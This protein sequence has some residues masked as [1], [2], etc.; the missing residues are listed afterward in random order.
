MN[1]EGA[2]E[3]G[4]FLW[5]RSIFYTKAYFGS[6][7]FHLRWF[8]I[9]H[10][11]IVS[12]PDRQEPD[13]HAIVYPLFH[14]IHVDNRRL[15][16][17]IIHPTEGR[18]DF[19]LMAPS[20]AIFDAVVQGLEEYMNETRPLRMQGMTELD[21]GI[22]VDATST[23]AEKRDIDADPHV[24]LIELPRNATKTELAF[25]LSVYPPSSTYALHAA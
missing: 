5:Q 14:E 19:T 9:T 12:V 7:A 4:C 3:I 25:W 20:K 21:D 15:I 24:D 2:H 18:R 13:K 23:A 1:N 17:N 10:Q 8:T 16:I 22:Q 6:H 11:R